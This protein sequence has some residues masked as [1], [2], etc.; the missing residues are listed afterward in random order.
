MFINGLVFYCLK[1]C[2]FYLI[3]FCASGDMAASW[4]A[5]QSKQPIPSPWKYPKR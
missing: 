3:N 2:C 1:M 4:S 5:V